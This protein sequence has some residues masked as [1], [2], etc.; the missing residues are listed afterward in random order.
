MHSHPFPD[1]TFDFEFSNVF[2]HALYQSLFLSEIERSLKP[3][4]VA[5]LHMTVHKRGDK[6]SANDLYSAEP[7]IGLVS[8][9]IQPLFISGGLTASASIQKS[10][11]ARTILI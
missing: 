10:L 5:V 9:R 3:E 11:F 2:D 7:L 1:N 8:S 6:Y 4:G